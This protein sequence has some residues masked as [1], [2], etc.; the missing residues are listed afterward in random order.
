MVLFLLSGIMYRFDLDKADL[1]LFLLSRLKRIAT[2]ARYC[3]LDSAVAFS[4]TALPKH[5]NH[6][7]ILF[8]YHL[9]RG[10]RTKLK[11][12]YSSPPTCLRSPHTFP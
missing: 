10:A 11:S 9:P 12:P 8:F 7:L 3:K 4:L 6:V 5:R 1:L 2:A